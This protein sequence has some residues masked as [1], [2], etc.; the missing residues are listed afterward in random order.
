MELIVLDKVDQVGVTLRPDAEEKR[1]KLIA[2]AAAITV[3]ETA[4]QQE[5]AVA[6][7]GRIKT[8][9]N[10]V[11][12]ARKVVKGP[13]IGL[14]KK[15][16]DIAKRYCEPATD[17]FDRVQDLLDDYQRKEQERVAGL[18]RQRQAEIERLR[19]VEEQARKDLAKAEKAAA[20]PKAGLNEA[21]QAALA[22]DDLFKATRA[23]AVAASTPPATVAKTPGMAQRPTVEFEVT[24]KEALFKERPHWFDLIPKRS[25]IRAEIT[26]ET[27]LPGIR[28]WEETKLVV[29]SSW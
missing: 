4:E 10:A 25:I 6:C 5:E 28:V 2:A 21:E 22:E 14:G 7:L 11:E 18:E 20:K 19:L 3:V 27:K 9:L 13:V 23:T 12:A 29:R 15:I 26:K 1:D 8:M 24:D 16:D 17:A